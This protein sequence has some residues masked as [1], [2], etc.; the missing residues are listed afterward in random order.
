VA[1]NRDANEE[2]FDRDEQ[3]AHHVRGNSFRSWRLRKSRAKPE[4][5]AG[6]RYSDDDLRRIGWH[7]STIFQL[8]T[9]HAV[10]KGWNGLV[11]V[12]LL[13]EDFQTQEN[14]KEQSD[15]NFHLRFVLSDRLPVQR[16]PQF[17]THLG[18]GM[19]KDAFLLAKSQIVN[20]E[21]QWDAE[22]DWC[23]PQLFQSEASC[24]IALTPA[25]SQLSAAFESHLMM[26]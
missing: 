19:L 9:I 13:P 7:L 12:F 18:V 11:S 3:G 2:I 1:G 5:V 6:L 26:S 17:S 14:G 23:S 25:H 15:E 4:S 20:I 22:F 8:L 21:P 16:G 10:W 24:D